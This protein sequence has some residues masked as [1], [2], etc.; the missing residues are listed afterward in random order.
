MNDGLVVFLKRGVVTLVGNNGDDDDDDDDDD[1]DVGG[2][3][4]SFGDA[5][6]RPDDGN[7]FKLSD[8]WVG[9]LKRGVATLAGKS[10]VDDDDDDDCDDDWVGDEYTL[11]Q[12][13]LSSSY[14]IE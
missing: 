1:S 3:D 14:S 6:M 9:F 2:D 11:F 8:D 13:S 10:G 12:Y 4:D 7:L 5:V